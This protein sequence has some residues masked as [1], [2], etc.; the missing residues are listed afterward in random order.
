MNKFK[1]HVSFRYQTATTK[2][3]GNSTVTSDVRIRA[4]GQINAIK[5]HLR[6]KLL[7]EQN[8]EVTGM[9]LVLIEELHAREGLYYKK[10]RRKDTGTTSEADV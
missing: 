2:G 10:D 6:L 1:Y 5:E 7:A 9:V 8:I 4:L 3:F